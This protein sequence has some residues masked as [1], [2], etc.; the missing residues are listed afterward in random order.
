MPTSFIDNFYIMDPYAPPPAGTALTATN[1][2]VTDQNSDGQLDWTAGDS[3]HGSMIF[4]S[5]PG[6]TVTVQV[7]GGSNVTVTGVTFYLSDGTQ[8]FSPI[9]GTTLHN[10]TFVSSTWGA[11]PASVTPTQMQP[12]CFTPGTLIT[13]PTGLRLIETLAVGDLVETMDNGAQPI[14]WIGRQRVRGVGE[15]APIRFQPGALGNVRELLVSQQ[16]RMLL[17]GWRAELMFG[18]RQVLAAAKHLVNGDTVH[19]S[20]REGVEYLHLMFDCH[21]VIFAEGIPT[22]SFHPGDYVLQRDRAMLSELQAIFPGMASGAA[23]AWT[24]A[25]KVLKGF[26]AA[27]LAA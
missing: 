3:I 11:T 22:E 6:D 27:L 26:E 9:D 20:P 13:T 8:V 25:R 4:A 15:F 19:L 1:Y 21:E 14:R 18:E 7:A 12:T 23:P 16:H 2:T 17:S 24:T 10:A 5:Y